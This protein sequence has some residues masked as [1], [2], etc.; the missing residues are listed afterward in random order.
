MTKYG[1]VS[2]WLKDSV[3]KQ[4][5]FEYQ[6]KILLSMGI[7]YDH[8]FADVFRQNNKER[9]QL[10]KFLTTVAQEGDVLVVPTLTCLYSNI[11]ELCCLMYIVENTGIIIQS[12]DMDL[13]S[14]SDSSDW[15]IASQLAHLDYL[16]YLRQKHASKAIKKAKYQSMLNTGGRHKRVI[17]PIYR[18]AYEYLQSHTYSE[19]QL[20]FHL[21]KST[22]YRIKRQINNKKQ[23]IN[24]PQSYDASR[25]DL[26]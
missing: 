8:C 25:G 17:T 3:I 14:D 15:I 24:T 5:G 23:P 12:S 10:F 21:S 2:G 19:T 7:P 11:R 1:Y 18:Q 26:Q 13:S 6:A 20:K 16:H 4:D 22:L 9:Y